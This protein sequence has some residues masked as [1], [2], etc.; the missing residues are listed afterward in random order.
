M[1]IIFSLY[2]LFPVCQEAFWRLLK[3]TIFDKF[4]SS[5]VMKCV[6]AIF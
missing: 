4:T 5:A 3:N 6:C 2:L 1:K